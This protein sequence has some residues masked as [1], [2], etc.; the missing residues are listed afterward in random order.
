MEKKI[1]WLF[2]TNL[3]ILEYY[4]SFTNLEQFKTNCHDF[5]LLM[6]LCYLE[7]NYVDE[8]VVLRLKPKVDIK[9]I[10]FTIRGKTFTQ[11]FV[12]SF[13]DIYKFP[14]PTISFFRG[15][16]QEYCMI[17]KRQHAFFGN[18]LYLG[19][20]R[21][22]F[23]QYGGR[24]RKVLVESDEDL[25]HSLTYPFFK[26]ANNKI[27]YPVEK[28]VKNYD[29][30]WI[31]N[32]SEINFKG[33]EYFIS[34]V[35]KSKELQKI[36][37]VHMGNEP[38]KGID[39]CKKFGV[40]NIKFL[41]HLKRPEINTFLNESRLAIV[42][43][44]EYDGSPR[45]VTEVLMSGTPLLI[46]NKTRLL[47]FYKEKGVV[48]FDD[49]EVESKVI[50]GLNRNEELRKELVNNMSNISLGQICNLNFKLWIS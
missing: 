35:S 23:P 31:C 30:C 6:C 42:T 34:E 20:G 10:V 26:T 5:Y 24:Y 15:G 40:S 7:N 48:T 4:H 41:G 9:D 1:L 13:Y 3:R 38:G 27:F 21:R 28:Q 25:K 47:N 8:V 19:A 17:T 37:I 33:Q 22:V 18:S 12:N 44:N 49:N 50:E 45:V 43:S 46:R 29:L 39:L 11:K 2:R 14:K 16:F 36:S 32:F